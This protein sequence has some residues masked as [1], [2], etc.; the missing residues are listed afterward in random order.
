MRPLIGVLCL[1]AVVLMAADYDNGV[2]QPTWSFVGTKCLTTGSSTSVLIGGTTVGT[3]TD[4]DFAVGSFC[5]VSGPDGIPSSV[6]VRCAVGAGG[7]VSIYA[8]T[9]LTLGTTAPAGTWCVEVRTAAAA[10]AQ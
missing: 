7:V 5:S 4:S 1:A 6:A 2:Q 3:V 9:G 10:V 8:S